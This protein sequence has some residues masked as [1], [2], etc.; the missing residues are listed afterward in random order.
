MSETNGFRAMLA[1]RQRKVGSLLCVGLDPQPEALPY[2][3]MESYGL[4]EEE[5]QFFLTQQSTLNIGSRIAEACGAWMAG[6][7]QSTKDMACLFKPQSA[8]WEALPGGREVMQKLIRGIKSNYPDIPV[9]LDC[10]RGDIGRTQARYREAHLGL[11]GVD[12]MNFSPYMGMDCPA[13]LTDKKYS[14]HAIVG[15]CRTSN[16][17]AWEIQDLLL[18]DGRR[19]YEYVAERSLSWF[20]ELGIMDNAGL[21]M[22]AA[23]ETNKLLAC[24]HWT[25]EQLPPGEIFTEHFTRVRQ[26][27]DDNLWFLIPGV[28]AQG[29]FA[30]A[31]V[32]AAWAGYGSIAVNSSS[33]ISNASREDDWEEAAAAAARKTRNQLNVGIPS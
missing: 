33:A 17:R 20:Y 5:I 11:D 19:F 6:I 8:H 1:E 29:G 23:H 15:L 13:A 31:T 10:K 21:V 27:V 25:Q 22:G 16:L 7:V 18:P 2:E 26:I 30:E 32:R 3:F 4:T 12:G 24:P 14:G 28:G 9:L